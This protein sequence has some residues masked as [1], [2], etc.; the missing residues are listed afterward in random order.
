MATSNVNPI[1]TEFQNA[2]SEEV[3]TSASVENDN[4]LSSTSA[5]EE[6]VLSE[7]NLVSESDLVS[8]NTASAENSDDFAS[9]NTFE[10]FVKHEFIT[11][12]R[13]ASVLLYVP[14]EKQ[15]Y[16][17]NRA[18]RNGVAYLCRIQDC[19][20]RV[21][22]RG[23]RC[24][25]NSTDSDRHANHADQAVEYNHLLQLVRIRSEVS[26][27]NVLKQRSRIR[28]VFNDTAKE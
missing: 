27:P 1:E 4:A 19:N 9:P 14:E 5:S 25:I 15:L 8:P 2:V 13:V 28:E 21:Y 10:N 6:N 26:K 16:K 18:I 11:G 12:S 20:S 24:F 3:N 23:E 17:K 7:G 22:V